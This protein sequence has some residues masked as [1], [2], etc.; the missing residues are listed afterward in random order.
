MSMFLVECS[1]LNEALVK[2]CKEMIGKILKRTEDFVYNE[3]ATTLSN[4]IR[5]M[6]NEFNK[7]SDTSADLV[8]A[9]QYFET[10]KSQQRS[11]LVNQF[12][13]LID[14]LSMLH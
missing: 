7:K 1:Q 8:V 14:W 9:E 6:S 11:Q 2:I 3:T 10:S 5:N 4:N 13:D 12:F